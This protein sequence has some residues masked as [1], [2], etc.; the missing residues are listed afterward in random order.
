M[1][2]AAKAVIF[3]ISFCFIW[4]FP[5]SSYGTAED[6]DSDYFDDFSDDAFNKRYDWIIAV[7]SLNMKDYMN[8]KG[9]QLHPIAR[10]RINYRLTNRFGR[11]RASYD[12]VFFEELWYHDC[13][14]IGCRKAHNLNIDAGE[15]GVIYF[16]PSKDIYANHCAV[17]N[18]TVRLLLD[19]MLK[20]SMLSCVIVP[21]EIFAQ[22]QSDLGQFGF[23]SQEIK[24]D[25]GIA[26][27]MHIM[28]MSQP[29]SK[30]A[31]VYYFKGQ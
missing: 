16:K 30:E 7:D 5:C 21:D 2:R 1:N 28:L 12:P 3:L 10:E 14:P 8:Y 18:T 6:T 11:E 15:Q 20:K 4:L 29:S 22:V 24:P 25:T 23:Y 31:S 26:A 19:C 17:A 9:S 13:S 27:T